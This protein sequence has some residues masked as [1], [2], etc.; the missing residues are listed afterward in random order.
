MI[1]RVS[2]NS[3]LQR[4]RCLKYSLDLLNLMIIDFRNNDFDLKFAI[5]TNHNF[6][7]PTWIKS[8]LQCG[9]Q[10]VHILLTE[11]LHGAIARRFGQPRGFLIDLI[12]QNRTAAK[13]DTPLQ[14]QLPGIPIP[15]HPHNRHCRKKRTKDQADLAAIARHTK[16]FRQ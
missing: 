3:K 10:G 15:V 9:N 2:N 5:G 11:G 1:T 16:S 13:I 8:I 14:L 7:R 12:D 4:A 6:F